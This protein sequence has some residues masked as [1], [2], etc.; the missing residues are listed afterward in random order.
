[1][2]SG[3]LWNFFDRFDCFVI[4]IPNRAQSDTTLSIPTGSLLKADSPLSSLI[5][6]SLF[7]VPSTVV[8]KEMFVC[9]L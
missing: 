2:G 4:Q 9:R 1:M 5:Q 7:V 8:P 3:A 6:N